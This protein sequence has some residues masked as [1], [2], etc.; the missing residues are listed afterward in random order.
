MAG[1]VR[2]IME[3]EN[4]ETL[5]HWSLGSFLEFLEVID[6][7]RKRYS[8]EELPYHIIVPSLPGYTLSSGPPLTKDFNLEDVARIM[9]KLMVGL[10]FGTGYIAQGGDVGSFLCRILNAYYDEC[11]GNSQTPNSKALVF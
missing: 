2:F 8:A 6:I 11:K 5:S 10:G 9:N 1:Q 7:Y 3:G 4:F